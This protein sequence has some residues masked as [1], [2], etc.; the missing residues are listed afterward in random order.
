VIEKTKQVGGLGKS[1]KPRGGKKV[2][3]KNVGLVGQNVEGGNYTKGTDPEPGRAKK[4]RNDFRKK[5]GY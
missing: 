3:G 1:A 4:K 5:P 2:L